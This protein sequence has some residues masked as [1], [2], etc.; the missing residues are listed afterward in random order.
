MSTS[1]GDGPEVDEGG[2]LRAVDGRR[3]ATDGGGF[4]AGDVDGARFST[5]GGGTT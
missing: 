1:S 5:P 3:L 2:G 4:T